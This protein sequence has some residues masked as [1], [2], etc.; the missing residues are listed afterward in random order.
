MNVKKGII[1]NSGITSNH[2]E[3]G[4]DASNNDLSAHDFPLSGKNQIV[5][6]YLNNANDHDL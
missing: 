4:E 1:N 2:Q 3:S 5:I 6:P